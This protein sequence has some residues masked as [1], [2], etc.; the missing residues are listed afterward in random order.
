MTAAL[1]RL[2]FIVSLIDR[3]SGP[4]STMMKTMDRVTT[5]IQAGYQ[6]IGYGAAGLAATAFSVGQLV[7]PAQELQSALGD[8]ATMNVGQETLDKIRNA[9]LQ[10]SIQFGIAATEF[11]A[12]SYDIQS[13][14]SGLTG[15]ELTRFTRTSALLAKAT[16]SDTLTISSYISTMYGIFQTTADSIG[17]NNWVE[18]LA[19]QTQF[20]ANIFKTTG[21]GMEQAFSSLGAAA[22]SA[23]ISMTEQMAILGTLQTSMAGSVAGTKY[24]AFLMGVGKAQ[25]KLGLQFTDSVGR[26]LPMVDI[27][28]R[29]QGKF[30][31]LEKLSVKNKVLL[32]NAFG[33]AEAIGLFD[34]LGKNIAGLNNNITLIG[35]NNGMAKVTEAAMKTVMPWD[36]ASAAVNTLQIALGDKMI[37][38][39][40]PLWNE[41]SRV[42]GTLLRWTMLFPELTGLISKAMLTIFGA[43]GAVSLFSVG[44]GLAKLLS[45]GWA[46]AMMLLKA[47]LIAL[48][49]V[50]FQTLPAIWRFTTALLANPTTW[51]VIGVGALGAA[52]AAT[53][54]YWD[55]WTAAVI[56]FSGRFLELIGVF[57]LTESL[58]SGWETLKGWWGQFKILMGALNPFDPILAAAGFLVPS[59]IASWETLKGWWTQ[60][61]T[62][63]SNLDPFA[64]IGKGVQ[65]AIDKINMIPGVNI[66]TPSIPDIVAAATPA[67]PR[68]LAAPNS[69]QI[70]SGGL[71]QSITNAL[72]QNNNRRSIGDIVIQNYGSAPS[73]AQIR[74]E[75]LFAGG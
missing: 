35:Q 31:N 1:Q 61:K 40:T 54:I 25:D 27:L 66:P 59:A 9:A 60:F 4:A 19:A 2:E 70:Q 62:W 41:I 69:G 22:T 53:V 73:A 10:T 30:G 75:L 23:G 6:K 34:L 48:R 39:L 24:R 45:G 7:Q 17:R 55:Q 74:D 36:R 67:P 20:A 57:S 65:W 29:L 49:A 37:N 64:I 63:L 14:I 68:P 72:T 46:I 56:D 3:V 26:L 8:I 5:N 18:Q 32:T 51:V 43:I 38:V 13:A 42:S 21:S 58:L 47:P 16:K 15:D 52:I 50:I 44:V 71:T 33:S 12:G 11:V 28:N